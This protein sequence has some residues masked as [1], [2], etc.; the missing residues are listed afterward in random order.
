[1]PPLP[2]LMSSG[3][4]DLMFPAYALQGSSLLFVP[5]L[6][7]QRAAV[8]V[9]TARVSLLAGKALKQL[10]LPAGRTMSSWMSRKLTMPQ[11]PAV[12]AFLFEP[13]QPAELA[14][15]EARVAVL[16]QAFPGV[17]MVTL[18]RRVP[19]VMTM[20]M[21]GLEAVRAK[22]RQLSYMLP[23]VDVAHMVLSVPELLRLDVDDDIIPRIQVL[24]TLMPGAS[25]AWRVSEDPAILLRQFPVRCSSME[26]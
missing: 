1:V 12:S 6:H 8:S 15:A 25:L 9:V 18:A 11:A 14:A 10:S 24:R 22:M 17:E 20:D 23:E 19:A 5:M 13:M 7:L 4:S 26:V 16:G 21:A 3:V 2:G